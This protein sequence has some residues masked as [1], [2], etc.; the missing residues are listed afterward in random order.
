MRS[1]FF[2]YLVVCFLSVD[3]I[4]GADGCGK[5]VGAHV[6]GYSVKC[7]DDCTG[8]RGS[9]QCGEGSK[10][11]DVFDNTTWCCNGN[12]CKKEVSEWR[13]KNQTN[14]V[15]KYGNPI[16][17]TTT[18]NGKCNTGISY[19][20]ARQ[21]KNCENKKQCIKIQHWE[22]NTYHCNDRSDEKKRPEDAFLPI[23]WDFLTPC[24]EGQP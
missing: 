22:D 23:N 19:F 4:L 10:K 17:L 13:G 1:Y 16:P 8:P 18:C 6:G 5:A 2:L 20:A 15:W 12:Q 3:Q 11:F 21:Y 14:I 24:K 7:G 9:C